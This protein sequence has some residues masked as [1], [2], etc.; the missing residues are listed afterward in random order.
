MQHPAFWARPDT[1]ASR[2]LAPLGAL[3]ARATAWRAAR[4]PR[5]RAPVPVICAGNINVGG[6]GK[7]PTVIALMQML[8]ATGRAP[9]VISRGYG[10]RLTGPL[11]VDARRHSAA[12][13]GDEPLLLAAFAPVWVGRD[14]AATARAACAAGAEALILDDGFQ[15]PALAKDLSLVVVDAATGFG[16]G[17]VLPA[18]PLREP[19]AA[20]L[21]RADAILAI[22]APAQTAAFA[23][24]TALHGTPLLTGQLAPLATGMRWD[25]LRVLA[26]AGIGRPEKF[27]ATLR[28]QGAVLLRAEGLRDHQPLG[29]A[30]MTRLE[31]E[32]K[33]Q[34]AQMVTTEKDAVRLPRAFRHKVLTLPVRLALDDPPALAARLAALFVPGR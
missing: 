29:T 33:A 21:A 27:F 1:P 23:A 16:N 3:Y 34:G 11:Q 13:V 8:Q 12:D 5:L 4:P 28:A 10:G 6:S 32:A 14:R 31:L 19:V 30:L 9:H 24:R 25:G 26:F 7:T 2:A 18:G 17:R 22:G 20:G 15:D